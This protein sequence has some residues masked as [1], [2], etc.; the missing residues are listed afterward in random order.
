MNWKNK[1][2]I[3][4][5]E[6]YRSCYLY[7][8]KYTT[9]LFKPEFASKTSVWSPVPHT[10]KNR[11]CVK[12][13]TYMTAQKGLKHLYDFICLVFSLE[14]IQLFKMIQSVYLFSYTVHCITSGVWKLDHHLKW[15]YEV[16]VF[17]WGVCGLKKAQK[18]CLRLLCVKSL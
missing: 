15:M 1:S 16:L 14:E 10:V 11:K 8:C 5:W 4:Q 3:M 12:L 13:Y 2:L 7:A 9:L 17:R 6:A 18:C